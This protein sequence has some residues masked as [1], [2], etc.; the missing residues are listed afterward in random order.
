MLVDKY[1]DRAD[2][3]DVDALCDKEGNVVITGIMQHIEQAR[4]CVMAVASLPCFWPLMRQQLSARH[5]AGAGLCLLLFLWPRPVFIETHSSLQHA[6]VCVGRC[7]RSTLCCGIRRRACTRA[8]RRASSQRRA[9]RQSAWP[10]SGSGH[11]SWRATCASSASST[12][13]TACRTTRCPACTAPLLPVPGTPPGRAAKSAGLL[14]AVCW[15][16]PIATREERMR[17]Q[18]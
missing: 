18:H 2:E 1:L 3:L 6:A 15:R 13:S 12:S 17:A 8:T 16:R 5:F 14:G 10:P 11:P 4:S 9:S 7:R